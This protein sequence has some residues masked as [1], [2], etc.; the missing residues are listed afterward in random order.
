MATNL[1]GDIETTIEKDGSLPED[2]L[3]QNWGAEGIT[4]TPDDETPI[5]P[6]PASKEVKPVKKELP[7]KQEDDEEEKERKKL[8]EKSKEDAIKGFFGEEDQKTTTSEDDDDESKDDN[9]TEDDEDGE[10]QFAYLSKQLYKTGIFQPDIDDDGNEIQQVAS[11]PEEF[12]TLFENQ[13]NIKANQFLDDVLSRFGE[14]RR[15]LFEAVFLNGVDPEKYFTVSQSIE[16]L[17][18]ISL[19]EEKNQERVVR[20]FMKRSGFSE[21]KIN[22]RVQRLKDI[23]ELKSHSEDYLPLLIQQDRNS[24]EKLSQDKAKELENEKRRDGFYKQSVQKIL[25]DK[26]KTKE[27]DGISLNEKT[28]NATFQWLIDKPYT[29]SKGKKLSELDVWLLNLDRPENHHLKVKLALLAQNN[30][31]LSKV[32]QKALTKET[33]A[34]FQKFASKSVKKSNPK[35]NSDQGDNSW[36]DVLK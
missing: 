28:A 14:D 15:K 11:N 6:A 32:Q 2:F 9:T 36:A 31:D 24:Q 18:G 20:E 21:D 26:L 22:E 10:N 4:K 16:R 29:D 23:S 8:E 13:S 27:F 3:S 33:G 1:F 30:L 25:L 7:K 35:V 34:L 12:K 17:E 19:D 5:K